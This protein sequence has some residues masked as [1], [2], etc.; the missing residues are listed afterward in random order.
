[1]QLEYGPFNTLMDWADRLRT[2]LKPYN[3]SEV[4][5]DLDWHV[6]RISQMLGRRAVPNAIDAVKLCK[7]LNVSVIEIFSPEDDAPAAAGKAASVAEARQRALDNARHRHGGGR[8]V[9]PAAKSKA[10]GR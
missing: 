9:A 1:M 4:A 5:R 3:L 6:T 2:V 10:S 8:P 7:Y